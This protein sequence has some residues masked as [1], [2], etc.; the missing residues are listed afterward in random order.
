[1]PPEGKTGNSATRPG[2]KSG[3]LSRLAR[4]HADASLDGVAL[5][6]IVPFF[7]LPFSPS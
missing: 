6:D 7:A 5:F 2:A 1:M 3:T 4:R